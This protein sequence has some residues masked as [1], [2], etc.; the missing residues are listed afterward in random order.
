M[1]NNGILFLCNTPY[2]ILVAMW[3]KHKCF[4]DENVDIIISD[5][6]NGA[7][8]LC[9]RMREYGQFRECYFVKSF[10]FSYHRVILSTGEKRLAQLVPSWFIRRFINLK[11]RY[12]TVFLANVDKFS[13]LLFNALKGAELFLFEDGLSTY[14]NSIIQAYESNYNRMPE[15]DRL[16]FI[17]HRF[18]FR[19]QK[20]YGS[21]KKA[22]LFN[23]EIAVWDDYF[24]KEK[25]PYIDENDYPFKEMCNK[26]FDYSDSSEYDRKY[27]FMEESFVADGYEINDVEIVEK[28][29][30]LIGKDNII[31]KIHPRNPENRFE[32]LGYKT[33][34]NIS[35]PWEVI[36]MNLSENDEKI[37]V[38]IS[39]ACILNP[40]MIFNKRIKAYALLK[41]VDQYELNR[42]LTSGT[43]RQLIISLYEKYYP[44]VIICNSVNEVV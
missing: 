21:I 44:T 12:K 19:E 27:I 5:H 1:K 33:N 17:F 35:I 32:K 6:M 23:P 30:D 42:T 8:N 13:A 29:S 15:M 40:L 28:I 26:L 11:Y 18:F 9:E 43:L 20:I 24:E 14:S 25:I 7:E 10:A 39:S 2:Q 22:Y 3:M 31:V 34:H 16:H 41:C 37:L 4:P 36:A 38:T